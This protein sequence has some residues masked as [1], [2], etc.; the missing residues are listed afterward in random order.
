VDPTKPK[1][2]LKTRDVSPSVSSAATKT[3]KKSFE[4]TLNAKTGRAETTNTVAN[5]NAK[6]PVLA[7]IEQADPEREAK[8]KQAEEQL[9]LQLVRSVLYAP[10]A[11]KI[12][13]D[14]AEDPNNE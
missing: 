5:N 12:Q 8:I 6:N 14:R 1:P 4:S 9:Q 7:A 3:P 10:K 2:T 13:I 11:A